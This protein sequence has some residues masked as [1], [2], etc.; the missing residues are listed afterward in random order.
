MGDATDTSDPTTATDSAPPAGPGAREADPD[1]DRDAQGRG[2]ALL[3]AFAF[4]SFHAAVLV[5]AG[6]GTLYAAGGLGDALAGLSTAVG[7]AVYG[8]LWV[9]SLVADRG[10]LARAPPTS[11]HTRSVLTAAAAWGG[12]AGAAVLLELL[13]VRVVGRA[14]RGRLRL[15]AVEADPVGL[16]ALVAVLGVGLAAALLVGSVVGLALAALDLA[17]V[18]AVRATRAGEGPPASR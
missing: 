2:G 18:R 6:V 15:P 10:V 17:V 4:G 13:A 3:Q 14:I 16:F 1:R 9:T 12:L 11:A 8:L 7:L 5:V